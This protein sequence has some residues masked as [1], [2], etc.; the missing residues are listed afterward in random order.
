MA[1]FN[2]RSDQPDHAVRA[3]RAG[4]EL[5]RQIAAVAAERPDWSRE[6]VGINTG[7]AQ[8]Q[9]SRDRTARVAVCD[10]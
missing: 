2:R 7:P 3:A 1:T 6:R 4:L 5:Q 9:G 10:G 8:V